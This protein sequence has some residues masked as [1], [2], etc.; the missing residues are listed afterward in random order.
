MPRKRIQSIKNPD[1]IAK[2]SHVRGAVAL[3]HCGYVGLVLF[4]V[5]SNQRADQQFMLFG[6]CRTKSSDFVLDGTMASYIDRYAEKKNQRQEQQ[7]CGVDDGGSGKGVKG[8]QH[9]MGGAHKQKTF[10][11]QK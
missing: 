8:T 5:H 1:A 3:Y 9:E 2:T 10:S 7:K 11:S 4:F 6:V